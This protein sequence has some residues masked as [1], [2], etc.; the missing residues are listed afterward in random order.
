MVPPDSLSVELG[1]E[2]ADKH[3]RSWSLP[4]IIAARGGGPL[5]RGRDA[6]CS[7]RM[8]SGPLG[9]ARQ[10]LAFF[11]PSQMPGSS[12]KGLTVRSYVV[13]LVQALFNSRQVKAS[14]HGLHFLLFKMIVGVSNKG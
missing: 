2:T 6:G 12:T 8:S 11:P 5:R 7:F 9:A 4:P 3:L 1:R 14:W 10:G 13:G